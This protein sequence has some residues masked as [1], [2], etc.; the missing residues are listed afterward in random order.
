MSV[1]GHVKKGGTEYV[2]I[3]NSWGNFHDGSTCFAVDAN[4]MQRWLAQAECQS[5]GEIDLSDNGPA[6]DWGTV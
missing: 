6:I 4:E 2:I 1:V 5:V 3:E